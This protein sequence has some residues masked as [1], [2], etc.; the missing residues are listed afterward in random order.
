MKKYLLILLLQ[1]S[2][3]PL[4]IAQD[5]T[6]NGITS[7]DPNEPTNWTP[8]WPSPNFGPLIYNILI[9]VVAS[10]NYPSFVTCSIGGSSSGSITINS[11][12]LASFAGTTTIGSTGTGTITN[13]GDIYFGSLKIGDQASG[14]LINTGSI[15][16]TGATTIGINAAGNILNSGII[17]FRNVTIG[18]SGI[19]TLDPSS[20]ATIQSSLTNNGNLN[21]N[22]S[23]SGIF[24]LI[25][26][27]YSGSGN[28]NT[29]LNLSGSGGPNYNWH[30]IAV[31]FTAGYAKDVFI[32]YGDNLLAY[33]DSRVT[34]SDFNGW[35][36]HDG[37]GG[38]P[39]IPP[40]GG[41]ST[42]YYGKGY[43]FYHT[44][45]YTTITLTGTTIGTNLG[46]PSLQYLGQ[47]SDPAM[48]GYNLL[49]NSLTCSLDLDLVTFSTGVSSTVYVTTENR[50]G[51]YN[52]GSGGANG[53]GR[54][55][56]PLQ[57]FFVKANATGGSVNLLGAK[58][59][60]T[61][62]RYKKSGTEETETKADIIYPKVKLELFGNLTSD[63]T[64]VWFNNEA[65]T[66]YDEKFDGYKLFSNDAAFGQLYST[67][68]GRNY[69]IN[70]IPLPT[71]SISV[72]LVIKISQ[73]GS[74]SLIKK[75][76][77]EL[78]SYNVYLIDKANGN[79]TVDLKNSSN[80]T[81]TSDAGTFTDRFVL[82]FVSLTTSV[83]TPSIINTKFNIYGTQNFIN[84]LPPDDFA[85]VSD[86]IV[87]IYDLTGRVVKQTNGI[88]LSR[89]SLVQIPFSGRQGIY[90]VEISSGL[91]R[92][93]GK[94]SV[95]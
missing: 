47:A 20:R 39:G 61:Q 8:N 6:W 88:G 35:A 42:L 25:M 90:I 75:V 9:P 85:G 79:Y 43:N 81:F 77:E 27:T 1:V 11:G 49:G 95:R 57:G 89:G 13:Y 83:E 70:G 80:Y 56:P 12:A 26:T 5:Y 73:S 68:E 86:G 84:I 92:Y 48:N 53:G 18:T 46:T 87:K 4:I 78:D 24:S 33:D 55:I 17:S 44:S 65:T 3:V 32:A 34:T 82:R 69:V 14:S 21:L 60:S 30:Y 50:W 38:T 51:S 74:Y 45:S 54:Y 94:V 23:I 19:L 31:P 15:S 66:G 72:P 2:L 29:Q 16:F 62:S 28:V 67:L 76:L 36:W 52:K 37:Y 10:T 22:S 58:T 59:H 64:I 91:S 40:L 71:E 63:E 93:K 7:D 41:F